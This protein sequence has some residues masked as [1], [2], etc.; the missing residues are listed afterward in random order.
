MK[1][2]LDNLHW[3][4]FEILSFKVLQHLISKDVQFIEGGNDKGRDIIHDGISNDFKNDWKG[5][6]LFQVKHKSKDQ[7]PKELLK[8]LS[9]DLERELEKVFKKHNYKID[10][11]V[12]VINKTTTGELHDSLNSKF[13]SF[14][15]DNNI[16]CK[17]FTIISY[18]HIE[19]CIDQKNDLKWSYPNIISQPDF[20]IL[21]QNAFNYKFE[22][23]KKGWL[24]KIQTQREK[25]VF[26]R[27][28]KNAYNKL[29]EYPAIILSG[30]PKSGKTFNAEI[31]SLNYS[32]Y[33]EFQPILIDDPDEIEIAYNEDRKQIFICDDAFGRHALTLRVEEWFKKLER[34]F[35]LA[36]RSHLFIFTSREYILRAFK[37]YGNEESSRFLKKIIVESHN[38][39]S[40]EKLSILK[41]YTTNSEI[42]EYDKRRILVSENPITNHRNFSPETI[43]AFFSN[44]NKEDEDIFKNLLEHLEE[45][46]AYLTTIF[47][48][49]NDI[50]QAAILSVLCAVQNDENSIFKSFEQICRDLNIQ[51]IVDS[52][53]EFEELD[54]SILRI[55]K[56]EEIEEINFYHPSMQE[57]LIRKLIQ[58]ETGKLSEVVLQN[59]NIVLLEISLIKPQK[60]P[61]LKAPKKTI[62][63]KSEDLNYVSTGLSRLVLKPNISINQ[64]SSV[65]K[66]FALEH[67]TLDLKILAKPEFDTIKPVVQNILEKITST[68]FYFNHKNENSTSWSELLSSIKLS[69]FQY[70]AEI[71]DLDFQYFEQLIKDKKNEKDYWILAFRMIAFAGGDFIVNNVGKDWLNQFYLDLKKEIFDLGFELFGDDFPKFEKFN[72]KVKNKEHSQKRKNKPNKT[73]YPRF[74]DV[75]DKISILKEN[76]GSIV[77]TKILDKLIQPYDEINQVSEYAKNRHRFNLKKGWW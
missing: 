55:L 62:K 27:F 64:V 31:L 14:V 22:T 1:Y 25:F 60:K 50:K 12:L 2:N 41:R 38:Y 39:T 37:N 63:I 15:D 29:E 13:R 19:S 77:V 30:P 8:T 42:S 24:K 28:F 56:D 44:I 40:T 46:D 34:I 35:N 52:R 48:R 61:L 49:F 33:R 71:K 9:Q 23:R 20:Q 70:G 68:T 11:Y 72:A 21:I 5:K 59:L 43:R 36:D 51:K 10:N 47:F 67:H 16:E 7:L 45:P 3:Q 26:T 53:I 74:I 17:N 58:R 73:W 65:F 32:L 69:S 66:W 6:W 18:R 76:K 57:F 75:K 4:E 54:D